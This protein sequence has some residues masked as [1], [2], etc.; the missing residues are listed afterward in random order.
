MDAH[1][2]M[3]QAA[4]FDTQVLKLNLNAGALGLLLPAY[5]GA[6]QGAAQAATHRYAP[7]MFSPPGVGVGLGAIMGPPPLPAE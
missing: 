6:A 2:M 7:A 1:Q 3:S 4:D 5:V